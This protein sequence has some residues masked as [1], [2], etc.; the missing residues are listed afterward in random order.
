MADWKWGNNEHMG[1]E[2][3][4]SSYLLF[5]PIPSQFLA[6]NAKVSALID[7]DTHWWKKDL[8]EAVFL[9]HEAKAILSIPLSKHKSE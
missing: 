5:H 9:P 7:K 4:P 3:G 1:R 6:S 2:M 8:I